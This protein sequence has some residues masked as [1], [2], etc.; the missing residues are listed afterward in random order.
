MQNP[1]PKSIKPKGSLNFPRTTFID[2]IIRRVESQASVGFQ[3]ILGKSSTAIPQAIGSPSAAHAEI[4]SQVGGL[5]QSFQAT[6]SLHSNP[7]QEGKSCNL[8]EGKGETSGAAKA[9]PQLSEQGSPKILDLR[10][11]VKPTQVANSLITAEAPLEILEYYCHIFD[12][13]ED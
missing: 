9:E 2:K 10:S 8:R 6:I 7:I 4:Q 3:A 1:P 11:A 5:E 12:Q 13:M